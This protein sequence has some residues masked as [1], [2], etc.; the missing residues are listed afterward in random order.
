VSLDG[1]I[2]K[3][4]NVDSHT[5]QASALSFSPDASHFTF[6]LQDHG[7]LTLYQ[8]GSRSRLMRWVAVVRATY[9]TSSAL[10]ASTWHISA[11]ARAPQ[12]A[13]NRGFA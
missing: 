4:P 3:M 7:G 1:K 12:L 5:T 11:G 10:T 9:S 6:A 8:M 13:L 2:L